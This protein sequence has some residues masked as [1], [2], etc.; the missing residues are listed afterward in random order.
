MGGKKK[1]M[2]SSGGDRMGRRTWRAEYLQ[3]G[4]L[5]GELN[6]P[7]LT[8]QPRLNTLQHYQGAK[9]VFPSHHEEHRLSCPLQRYYQ[10]KGIDFNK[11]NV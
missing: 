7:A 5:R 11:R 8:E 1:G 2:K 6:V 4:G 3:I 10:Q 9:D